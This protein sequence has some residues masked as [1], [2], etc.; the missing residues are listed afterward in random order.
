MAA[1]RTL[2]L[3]TGVIPDVGAMS[4]TVAALA[5]FGALAIWQIALKVGANFLF[6]RPDAFWIA[7]KKPTAALQAAE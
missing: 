6:E 2:L 3:H 5:L 7:P 1:T 4:L